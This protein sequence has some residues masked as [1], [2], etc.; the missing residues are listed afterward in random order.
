MVK[1]AASPARSSRTPNLLAKANAALAMVGLKVDDIPGL[2]FPVA[3]GIL[4]VETHQNWFAALTPGGSSASNQAFGVVIGLLLGL[5][6]Y[7]IKPWDPLF[8]WLYSC[9]GLWIGLERSPLLVMPNPEDL[10]RARR[11]AIMAGVA[12]RCAGLYSAAWRLA[13][14]SDDA[15]KA[16]RLL[17]ASKAF[18]SVIA[19]SLLLAVFVLGFDVVKGVKGDFVFWAFG[20]L[21]GLAFLIPYM[22]LRM[23]H[24]VVLYRAA[25]AAAQIHQAGLAHRQPGKNATFLERVKSAER[26]LRH[27]AARV[28]AL[29]AALERLD[30]GV[31]VLGGLERK[32][33][34]AAAGAGR[35]PAPPPVSTQPANVPRN[36]RSAADRRDEQIAKDLGSVKQAQ[37]LEPVLWLEDVIAELESTVRAARPTFEDVLLQLEQRPNLS[38]EAR[39]LP[40]VLDDCCLKVAWQVRAATASKAREVESTL[41]PSFLVDRIGAALQKFNKNTLEFVE[42]QRRL[43]SLQ[44]AEEQPC[45]GMGQEAPDVEGANLAAKTSWTD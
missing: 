28:R 9:R 44:C 36:A 23:E 5:L 10:V 27:I 16:H 31:L 7:Y 2:P 25:A 8:D 34:E 26:A 30:K 15:K 38:S 35:S 11:E 20:G 12:P 1:Q 4:F 37:L 33:R 40:S 19:P 42:W 21:V 22:S 43:R 24:M 41:E 3:V 45:A 18:R 6:F 17:A 13:G 39:S 29:A 14:S 32:P